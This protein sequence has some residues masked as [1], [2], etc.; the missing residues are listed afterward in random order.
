MKAKTALFGNSI[1]PACEYCELGSKSKDGTMIECAKHGIVSPYF[2][3]KKFVYAPVKR[4]P[5]RSP[6]HP[7][8]DAQDFAL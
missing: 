2:R 8:L 4:I 7:K 5:R 1:V 3:C 6:K